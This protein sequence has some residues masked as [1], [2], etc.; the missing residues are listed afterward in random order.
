MSFFF[1]GK[2]QANNQAAVSGL[3][4]QSS[5]FGKVIPKVYG[6][7]R[8]APN[9]IW[10]GDFHSTSYNSSGGSGGGG[11]GGVGGG[12]GGKGGGGSI[13]YTYD[14]T[15]LLAL[16]EGPIFDFGNIY[17][18]KNIY[19]TSSLGFAEFYGTYSQNPW[20][21]LTT[22]HPTEALNYHGI[23][24]VASTNYQLGNSAQL[25]N[26]NFEIYGTNSQTI[27][28][29]V[30]ADAALVVS[31]LLANATYGAGFT[32]SYNFLTFQA[33]SVASGLWISPAYQEQAPCASLLADI[34][35]ACNS[36]FVWSSAVLKI[37]PY[38]DKNITAHGYTYTAPSAPEY[39]LDDNDFILT[40][41]EGPISLLRKRPA[42]MFN[43]IKIECVDRANS[44]NPTIVEA[45]DQSLIDLYGVRQENKTLHLF[46]DTTAAKLSA[47]LL[48]QRQ[49]VRNVF[50]FTL[51]QRYILLD[52]MDIVAI[53][54]ATLGLDEQ[55]VRII[56]I[57][58]NDDYSLTFTA[59][60]YL[61]GT[62]NAPNYA[63]QEAAGFT[64]DY[65]SAPGNINTPVIFDAPVQL[66]TQGEL[67]TW[68]AASG[69]A[70][71]GGCDVYV[72]SD[73][74]TYRFAGRIIGNA[75][76]GVLSA[77]FNS[78][79]DPDTTENCAVNLTISR[80]AL[81]SGTQNDADLGNTLCYV[82]GELIAYQTAELTSTYNYT[83]KDYI[84]RGMYGTTI[85]SHSSGTQFAR[86]DG[87]IFQ[88]P[89]DKTQIGQTFY[90]KFVSFNIYGGGLQSLADV[91]PYVHVITGPPAPP[92]VTGFAVT[93][94][95]G[96]TVFTWNAVEDFALK[97]YDI[98]F[99]PQGG[100]INTATFLTQSGNGTEMTNA[101]VP[102][103]TWTFYIRARDVT[104]RFSLIPA[105][106]DATI[107]T[108]STIIFQDFQ[109]S[110][111]SG[112][113][114]NFVKHYTGVL[115]PVGTAN[116]DTYTQISAPASPT[117]SETLAGSLTT[118][119]YYVQ[120]TYVNQYGS[121]TEPSAEDSFTVADNYVLVVSSPATLSGATGWNVYVGLT[122]GSGTLQNTTP[123][124]IGSDWTESTSGLIAGA[125]LPATN[126]TGWEVFDIFVVDPVTTATYTSP[127]IDSEFDDT[128]RVWTTTQAA[129]GPEQSGQANILTYIDT[130]LT[131]EIDPAVYNIWTIGFVLMRY[132][133]A[134]FIL[135]IT[136]GSVPY[137]TSFVPTADR[138]PKIQ[139][140]IGVVIAPGGTT[141]T[142]PE[143]YHY[144]PYVEAF[145]ANPT[146]LLVTETSITDTN[147]LCNVFNT[148]G[149]DVGGTINY[150]VTGE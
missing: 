122:P 47:Q 11:K 147:F 31:D 97:G 9:L 145:N 105:T 10:Y 109:E 87:G 76:Q 106:Y 100:G 88:Y 66:N 89:Y 129:M 33:Y 36:E 43:S 134:R 124:A 117:L 49:V 144:P 82:D 81:L 136:P 96:A 95:G 62:G 58:E 139:D 77:T 48:L 3:Q 83:L 107:V 54:D 101:A 40:S 15:I 148:S 17:I 143:R 1:K 70:N 13:S 39:S 125:A 8:V 135:T 30:D 56:D 41:A 140:V 35:L 133:K 74:A 5:A 64:V 32:Y 93:Q 110:D 115:V 46:A 16:C 72:S 150:R 137:I 119:T 146:A 71:W 51:D 114:V 45:K 103:G 138:Q 29:Q 123:Y 108:Q 26:F 60:E 84:R 113:L 141:V 6:T 50:T 94:N 27:S 23:A 90:I 12:G 19:N 21:Y 7:T 52:P 24:Y 14:T 67:E 127:V 92:N 118:D 25:P 57:T 42:D 38:G 53:T 34:T 55:W 78:S 149:T 121:E 112:T 44:Y 61:N 79:G 75:R 120:V 73:D 20:G 126:S 65:S 69:G 80:G 99:G 104:D 102:T 116:A 130:Y 128:L 142:F 37:V 131:G 98:L 18:D 4:L 85:S 86:L 111:W 132:L 59:E 91:S 68:I 22:N 28:G 63:Y 2:A